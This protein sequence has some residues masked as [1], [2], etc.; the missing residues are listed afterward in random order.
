MRIKDKARFVIGVIDVLGGIA[1]LIACIYLHRGAKIALT[2]V[3]I[4]CGVVSLVHSIE[5]K[6]ERQ[7]RKE[8]LMMMLRK[9]G[10]ENG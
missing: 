9:D 8:E 3:P 2:F 6:V 10:E 4:I 1:C 5:T 7:R